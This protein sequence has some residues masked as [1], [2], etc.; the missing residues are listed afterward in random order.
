MKRTI[1]LLA[2]LMACGCGAEAA[3]LISVQ[4]ATLRYDAP[5]Y[6]GLERHEVALVVAPGTDERS[7]CIALRCT[8]DTGDEREM[9][10]CVDAARTHELTV[11]L[12]A[13]GRCI[14]ASGTLT[15]EDGSEEPFPVAVR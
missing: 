10:L 2:A 3:D 8:A 13:K 7:A 1:G 12:H 6:A 11:G 5:A 9:S 4:S 15:H 14:S